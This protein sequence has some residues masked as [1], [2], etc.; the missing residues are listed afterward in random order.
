MEKTQVDAVIHRR[1]DGREIIGPIE[2]GPCRGAGE[3]LLI[4]DDEPFL[5]YV[6]G[7]ML[8]S[9][10]YRSVSCSASLDGLETFRAAP[11]AFDLVITDLVMPHLPGDQLA[12]ELLRFRPDLPIILCSGYGRTMTD[13]KAK[14]MG[15]RAF[16]QKPFGRRELGLAVQEA[17]RQR[18]DRGT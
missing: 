9:L 14:A 12:E 2:D 8:E 4:V 5:A 17:L 11:E 18:M 16:L 7:R 6:W 13:Q 15:I 3:R 1:F 10:G